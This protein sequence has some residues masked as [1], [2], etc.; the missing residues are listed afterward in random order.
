MFASRILKNF[1]VIS[2]EHPTI[3]MMIC[4][5]QAKCCPE[6]DLPLETCKHVGV[7]LPEEGGSGATCYR[8]Q[9]QRMDVAHEVDTA[10]YPPMQDRAIGGEG[11][12]IHRWF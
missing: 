5:G 11:T 6:S 7:C 2:K 1:F 3:I 4:G 9:R 10:W 12:C 8:G